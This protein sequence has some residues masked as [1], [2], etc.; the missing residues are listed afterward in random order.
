MVSVDGARRIKVHTEHESLRDAKICLC[1]AT[2]RSHLIKN[3][4]LKQRSRQR[5]HFLVSSHEGACHTESA[6]WPFR[7][8]RRRLTNK[9]NHKSTPH[10]TDILRHQPDGCTHLPGNTYC[11]LS[12]RISLLIV[13]PASHQIIVH[14]ATLHAI[15]YIQQE[16]TATNCL[17]LEAADTA[18]AAAFLRLLV[19]PFDHLSVSDL[20]FA[21]S[22]GES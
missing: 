3:T 16:H 5:L 15:Q 22:L 9:S 6:V 8:R 18:V 20:P 17:I 10:L 1:T 14:I 13:P 2:F 7:T 11:Q 21:K 12:I 19:C 4:H